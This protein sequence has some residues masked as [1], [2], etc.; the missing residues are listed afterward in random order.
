M[1]VQPAVDGSLRSAVTGCKWALGQISG[2]AGP[3]PGKLNIARYEM[4]H[5]GS[6]CVS[7]SNELRSARRFARGLARTMAGVTGSNSSM[8]KVRLVTVHCPRAAAF[9][10]TME[11]VTA[12]CTLYLVVQAWERAEV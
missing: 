12:G 10:R 11:Q 9:C 1:I 8:R 4:K 2:A 5:D 6:C 7:L 3:L